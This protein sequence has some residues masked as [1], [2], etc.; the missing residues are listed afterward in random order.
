MPLAAVGT[1]NG[2]GPLAL[3]FRQRTT[4]LLE[5]LVE[6]FSPSRRVGQ[7][8]A[9][10]MLHERRDIC[11]LAGRVQRANLVNLIVVESDGDLVSRHTKHHT[12][13]IKAGYP[14]GC[15]NDG[16]GSVRSSAPWSVTWRSSSRRM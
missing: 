10:G 16:L 11:R 9:H 15:S 12:M 14:K 7:S 1:K 13:T 5:C 3:F 6:H 4:S 8:D 2:V